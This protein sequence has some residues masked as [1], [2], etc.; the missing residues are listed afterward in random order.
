M[1]ETAISREQ[2][3]RR[4]GRPPGSGYDRLDAP[5]CERMRELLAEG[6]AAS[7]TGAAR[8]VAPQAFGFGTLDSK[9]RRLAR[10]FPGSDVAP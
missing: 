4:R 5:L 3:A 9:V 2:T 1:T 6:R 7:P 8:L 10:R